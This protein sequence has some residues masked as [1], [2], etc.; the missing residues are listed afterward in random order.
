MKYLNDYTNA[1][2]AEMLTK[3]GAFFAFSNSQFDEQ[4]DPA[5]TTKDYCHVFHGMYAPKANAE[6]LMLEYARIV[7]DGVAQDI[8]ENGFHNIILRE[9][10]NYEC[11]YSGDHHDA[12]QAL[13]AYDITEAMV[14]EVFKNKTNPSYE[15][16][17][18]IA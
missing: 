18:V 16:R 10:N 5:L 11:F 7:K 6:A 17:P 9:L 2:I 12:L 8:K 13:L 15:P 1:P 4:K 3:H 14:L